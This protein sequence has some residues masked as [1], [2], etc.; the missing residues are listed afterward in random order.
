[1]QGK[2]CCCDDDGKLKGPTVVIEEVPP[3]MTPGGSLQ[4]VGRGEELEVCY[5][6][7]RDASFV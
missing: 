6:R 5:E 4:G 2:D 1:M 3:L 7:A